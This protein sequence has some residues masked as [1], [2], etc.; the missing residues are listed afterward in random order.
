MDDRQRIA[1]CPAG[2][3]AWSR[4]VLGLAAFFS[5]S[6]CGCLP[7]QTTSNSVESKSMPKVDAKTEMV[8]SEPTSLNPFASA[9]KR[10]PKLEL[11]MA[12]YRERKAMATKDNPEQ[13][14]RELDEA[15]KMYQEILI[16]DAKNLEAIRGMAR[17][18]IAQRD[19]DRAVAMLQKGID[20]HPKAGVL[21]ADMSIAYSKRNDFA[22]AIKKLDQAR[23]IDPDN[24]DFMKML[25]VNYVCAGQ[26]DRGVEILSRARGKAA[27]HYYVARLFE[28]KGQPDLARRHIQLSLADNPNFSDARNLLTQL[29]QNTAPRNDRPATNPNVGLQFV[30]DE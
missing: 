15:R 4:R 12:N 30:N 25:G 7:G 18:Y 24:Q 2:I 8:E 19:Y 17:I 5:I 6:L 16:Y 26:V 14:F 13:Q 1:S 11:A 27:A 21:Y 23:A 20:V 9:P 22:S 29:D 3:S 10:E 28:R